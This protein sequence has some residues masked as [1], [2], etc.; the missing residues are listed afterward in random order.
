MASI[1]VDPTDPLALHKLVFLNKVH[2]LKMLLSPY[3]HQPEQQQH[4]AVKE[5]TTEAKDNDQHSSQKEATPPSRPQTHPTINTLDHHHLAPLHLAVMLNRKEAL[6]LL[7]DAGANP[8]V[9]SGSGWTPRQEATSIGDREMIELLT[10]YQRKEFSGSF[11]H[12]AMKLV[13]QLS[14]DLDQFYFQLQWEF[15]SWVPFVSGLCPNDTYHIWKKG[16]AVRMDTSLVGFENMKWIRGHISIIFRVDPKSGPELVI[17]D[18]VKKVTQRLAKSSDE[19]EEKQYD[20]TDE[21][22]EEEVSICFNSDITS[23]NVPTSAIKFHRAKQGM[24]GYRSN[25]VEKVGEYE[26]AVW[27]MEGVEFRT[28]VRTEH[29]KDEAGKP[30]VAFNRRPHGRGGHQHQPMRRPRHAR[31]VEQGSRSRTPGPLEDQGVD[32][33]KGT[34]IKSTAA[35]GASRQGGLQARRPA[36]QPLF[37]PFTEPG[38]EQD[39][40]QA[41]MLSSSPARDGGDGLA[42]SVEKGGLAQSAVESEGLASSTATDGVATMPNLPKKHYRETG[43]ISDDAFFETAL[44]E[45]EAEMGGI[46]MDGDEKEEEEEDEDENKVEYRASLVPP[47]APTVT[48]EEYFDE[49][50]LGEVHLGRP[51]EQKESHKT[52]GATLWMYEN[53]TSPTLGQGLSNTS[54]SSTLDLLNGSPSSSTVSLQ[55][56]QSP[57]PK[58]QFPLTIEKILPLLEVIGMDNN[59]LVGK[60]REFLEFKLPPGFPIRANIPVYPTLSAD[61]T[62]VNYDAHREIGSDMFEIP[63]E[64]DGFREGYVIRPGGS[65]DDT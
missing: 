5:T 37:A 35:G 58:A 57:E 62:F 40:P 18:R 56:S 45:A 46:T 19:E 39:A 42:V 27:K 26:C 15:Q 28:R 13:R 47:P 33:E 29:L 31:R 55:S 3:L 48:F 51:L 20:P 11:K 14:E 22:V 52:F 59:R 8:L 44:A 7:L 41:S 63:G 30:I 2:T 25:K 36:H 1:H 60:L 9:R 6:K 61:V 4:C 10:R 38:S 32:A 43:T 12:K 65:E 21:E 49:L 34:V 17:V 23:T 24:W 50:K 54:S 64:K 53:S 16:N